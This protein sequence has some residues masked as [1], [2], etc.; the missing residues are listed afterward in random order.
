MNGATAWARAR[1][2]RGL[3][4]YTR[5]SAILLSLGAAV[6][7]A[8]WILDYLD[9]ASLAVLALIALFEREVANRLKIDLPWRYAAKCLACVFLLAFAVH[10]APTVDVQA[11]VI[12]LGAVLLRST[13]AAY[14]FYLNLAAPSVFLAHLLTRYVQ[15]EWHK[16][17]DFSK[18]LAEKHRQRRAAQPLASPPP[19]LPRETT[20]Q[21]AA[22]Q[23]HLDYEF[24]C[25][26]V[27]S[28]GLDKDE[29]EAALL[30]AKQKYLRR[31]AQLLQ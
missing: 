8:S 15:S 29:Q 16:L 22:E 30:Q 9:T 20:L 7:I 17:R 1:L 4:A 6:E 25:Q 14:L 26:V 13:V 28:A 12:G 21:R 24:E 10:L 31:L 5:P 11:D 2:G 18:D 3:S 19:S 27:R 23:A